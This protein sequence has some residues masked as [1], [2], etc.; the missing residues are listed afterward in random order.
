MRSPLPGQFRF[1][2]LSTD[3]FSQVGINAS[4]PPTEAAGALRGAGD[5]MLQA[6]IFHSDNYQL[7]EQFDAVTGIEKRDAA[8]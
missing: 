6:V 2:A 4:T 8:S 1:D 7:S 5:R 3:F